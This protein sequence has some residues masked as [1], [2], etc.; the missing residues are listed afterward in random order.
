MTDW[1]NDVTGVLDEA[2][3]RL[4]AAGRLDEAA[5][6][7]VMLGNFHWYRGESDLASPY[8][9]RAAALIED[10]PPSRAKAEALTE[11]SRFTVLEDEDARGTELAR[12]GLA[13]AEE[14]GLEDV[15]VRL[16]NTLGVGRVKLG[17][18]GGIADIECA[19]EASATGSPEHL[20]AYINLSSTLGEL[21]E[22]A[23]SM[24]LHEE[25]LREAE[26]AGA[27]GP[28]RWLRGEL[29][30]DQY[31]AGNWDAALGEAEEFFRAAERDERHYMDAAAL[32][33]RALIRLGRDDE[34]GAL[35]DSGASLELGRA[36]HDAQVLYPSLAYES[37]ILAGVGRR[38]EAGLVADELLALLSSRKSIFP[39]YWTI[40]L[41][42]ALTTLG[43]GAEFEPAFATASISTTWFEASRA[44]AAGRFEEAADVYEGAGDLSDAAFARLRAAEALL[45]E[46]RRKEADAQLHRAL[47]FYRSVGA[48]AYIR[49]AE[50]LFAASA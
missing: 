31:L 17:D 38:E 3:E 1:R 28:A 7:E 49:E 33:V 37:Q 45:E 18:R 4:V 41:A 30:W 48:T 42:V 15:R 24:A 21:G 11:I 8:F 39:S 40:P 19:L 34:T 5:G 47:A 43:R 10:A 12:A 32:V 14:F 2:R 9:E 46:G 6:A 29:M 25:A 27:P 35:A 23:R 26:R 20:R 13:M 50:S 16:L 36:A 22:F 44:Y